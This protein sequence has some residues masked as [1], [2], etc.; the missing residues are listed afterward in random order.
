MLNSPQ[1]KVIILEVPY[2]SISI[3]NYSRGCL[4]S[5]FHREKDFTGLDFYRDFWIS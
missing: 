1:V 4:N 2:Y 3:W 5:D